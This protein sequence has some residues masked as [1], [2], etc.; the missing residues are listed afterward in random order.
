M[1]KKTKTEIVELEDFE[2]DVD[3]ETTN[4]HEPESEVITP[5]Q[6]AVSLGSDARTVRKFLRSDKGKGFKV[7]QGNRWQLEPEE[8]DGLTAAWHTWR[9]AL[10]A[11]VAEVQ[12]PDVDFDS[13]E[14]ELEDL[15]LEEV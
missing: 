14:V 15:E 2:A 11:K 13:D 9:T 7:G 4:G 10:N 8:L 1:G 5:K 12:E 3:E 6:L